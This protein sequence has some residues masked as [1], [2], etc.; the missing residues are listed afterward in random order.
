MKAKSP[1][2]NAA[3][4]CEKALLEQDGVGS[5]I[6][7]FDKLLVRKLSGNDEGADVVPITLMIILKSGDY[8]GKASITVIPYRPSG[9]ERP[10]L[11]LD[12]VFPDQPNSGANVVGT[13]NLSPTEEGVYWFDVL[14]NDE[15]ITRVPLE[16]QLAPS[17]KPSL[18]PS[19]KQETSAGQKK[20]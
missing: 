3:F 17:Q 15:L 6:R 13:I 12:V 2:L 7:I 18:P 10:A 8:R 9:T 1:Y 20:Q 4:F 19:P 5:A 11:K 14:L 16:I